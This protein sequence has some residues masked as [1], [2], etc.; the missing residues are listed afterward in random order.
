M[1]DSA[2]TLLRT[3]LT[4]AVLGLA[5]TT[6]ACA[7]EQEDDPTTLEEDEDGDLH[8]SIDE[9]T[10]E[11]AV[12]GIWSAPR[13]VID[14][15]AT[16]RHGYEGAGGSC[17]GGLLP[18]S[19]TLGDEIKRKFPGNIASPG[20]G[21]P[22]V[23]G[24]NCRRVRGGGGLSLHAT[25]R[26]L[27][28]FIPRS[29]GAADNTKGDAIANWLVENARELGVQAVIWDR[30]AWSVRTKR[31]VRYTGL[32][33]HDDHVHVELVAAAAAERLPWYRAR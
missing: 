16:A 32:H 31:I 3:A 14:K 21:L 4:L 15:G 30:G 18:G 11:I 29:R 17:S 22:A 8:D 9:S 27:D 10:S 2:C 7:V 23:Q 20:R 1:V 13:T 5:A 12:S 25:G 6:P 28:V 33:P 26:A 24:Y 19:R